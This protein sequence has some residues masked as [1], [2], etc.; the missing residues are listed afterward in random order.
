[1]CFAGLSTMEIVT[2]RYD[3]ATVVLDQCGGLIRHCHSEGS[4]TKTKECCD[5]G[6]L[7]FE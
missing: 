5:D 4:G 2:E 6:G 7:H 3:D 1:M